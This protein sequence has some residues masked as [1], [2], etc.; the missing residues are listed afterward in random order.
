[1]IPSKAARKKIFLVDDH[2]IV[3]QG[4]RRLIEAEKDFAVCGEAGGA[5]EALSALPS[6]MPDVLV[7]DLSLEGLGGLDLIKAVRGRFPRLPVLVISM[8]DESTY[9]ER[10]FHAGARGYLMKKESA[11]KVITALRQVL[12]GK[13][14]MSDAL[15]EKILDRL[16]DGA[17]QPSG[18]SPVDLLSDRELE[19]FRLIGRGLRL[20]RIADELHLSVKTVDSYREQIK[21][22][23][24]LDH[25]ADLVPYAIEWTHSMGNR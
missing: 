24:K 9:A 3:R 6:A 4:L 19:V 5:S 15:K 8:Y 23:L 20:S 10:T 7:T 21:A 14:Y 12:S 1:M 17:S 2:A 16:S 22:K 25:A 18:A 13:R 11:E